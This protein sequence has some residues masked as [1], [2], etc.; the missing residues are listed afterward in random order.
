MV[1]T[2]FHVLPPS[3]LRGSDDMPEP[4]S[5]GVPPFLFSTF[6][7]LGG[8]G[9]CISFVVESV[10]CADIFT[11]SRTHPQCAASSALHWHRRWHVERAGYWYTRA[12]AIENRLD[13]PF[14]GACLGHVYTHVSTHIYDICPIGRVINDCTGNYVDIF[15]FTPTS[16][17]S[18]AW[19]LS[20]N[21][22]RLPPF[23]LN[24]TN[25]PL[26]NMHACICI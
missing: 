24:K 11:L 25:F 14:S 6:F 10:N 15:I 8:G 3:R 21:Y 7:F 23:N 13:V 26:S 1:P 16:P 9:R 18:T 19:E 22:R 4:A 20:N 2:A 12:G 5:R 17:Q